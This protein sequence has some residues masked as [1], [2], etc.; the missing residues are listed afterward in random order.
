MS[1]TNTDFYGY[2]TPS[3]A[4]P[5]YELNTF[6]YHLCGP[7]QKQN[8]KAETIYS[9]PYLYNYASNGNVAITH[10]ETWKKALAMCSQHIPESYIPILEK[11]S[12]YDTAVEKDLTE[13]MAKIYWKYAPYLSTKSYDFW[14]KNE[15]IGRMD[16]EASTIM[17]EEL[18]S[19]IKQ[20][21][22]Y[23]RDI[24]TIP[25]PIDNPIC[26]STFG[27]NSIDISRRNDF[28]PSVFDKY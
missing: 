24:S 9:N 27:S 10:D 15:I 19:R 11:G 25:M 6:M 14:V 26:T 18:A 5:E 4:R 13:I 7:M 21:L 20:M 16:A 3:H 17:A 12:F 28:M 1:T 23:Y 22:Y 8:I 2:M